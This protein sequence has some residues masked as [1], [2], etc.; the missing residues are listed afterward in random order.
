VEEAVNMSIMKEYAD[1]PITCDEIETEL[2]GIWQYQPNTR[3]EEHA[4]VNHNY[5]K[6]AKARA[7]ALS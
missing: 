5:P 4:Y 3:Q 2:K 7:A 6:D 1:M